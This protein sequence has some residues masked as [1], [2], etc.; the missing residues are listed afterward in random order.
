MSSS[1]SDIAATQVGCSSSV[2]QA[3]LTSSS[4]TQASLSLSKPNDCV[5]NFF[6]G[7]EKLQRPALSALAKAHRL[8]VCQNLSIENIR[9]NISH[10]VG[11]I[12]SFSFSS[13]VFKGCDAVCQQ[14]NMCPKDEEDV[15]SERIMFLTAILTNMKQCPLEQ[16]LKANGINFKPG[17]KTGRLHHTLNKHIK[18]L[19]KVK[20]KSD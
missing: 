7:Y 4:A 15:L 9:D 17:S 18:S 16:L 12:L 3:G 13:Q 11:T 14:L 5:N 6:D 1:L 10:H 2:T 19:Q 20:S 8:S